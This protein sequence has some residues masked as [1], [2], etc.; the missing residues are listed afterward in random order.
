MNKLSR[1]LGDNQL[2]VK[3]TTVQHTS[4]YFGSSKVTY[5]FYIPICL[6]SHLSIYLIISQKS[7]IQ[8]TT[9]RYFGNL[10]KQINIYKLLSIYTNSFLCSFQL[11]S[12][13][14]LFAYVL[15]RF[16]SKFDCLFNQNLSI[17]LTI[18]IFRLIQLK[19]LKLETGSSL[20]TL[21]LSQEI[22]LIKLELPLRLD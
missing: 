17:Y 19:Q 16:S 1:I 15:L 11:S 18:Y 12:S 10:S 4:R 7:T 5:L 22:S 13:I 6:S 21:L 8:R 20:L 9:N 14:T 2:E 3:S